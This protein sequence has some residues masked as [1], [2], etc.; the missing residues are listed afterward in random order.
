MIR[1]KQTAVPF[2]VYWDNNGIGNCLRFF[3]HMPLAAAI[4]AAAEKYRK[5]GNALTHTILPFVVEL[6]LQAGGIN[7]LRA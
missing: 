5:C 1:S 6:E 4:V 7:K 3:S 2:V